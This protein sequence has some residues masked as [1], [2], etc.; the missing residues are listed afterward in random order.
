MKTISNIINN[1]NIKTISI[2]EDLPTGGA[3]KLYLSNI[4]YIGRK[5]RIIKLGNQD[6]IT[7]IHNIGQYYAH[8][9]YN[10][11]IRPRNSIIGLNK[12]KLLLAY[13]SWATKSPILLRYSN[14]PVIYV[15]HELP[16]EFYDKEY[17][18]TFSIKEKVIN[19]IGLIIKNIDLKNIQSTRN[20]TI[21][22]NSKNS[23]KRIY[24]AYR[25]MPKI[26]YPGINYHIFGDNLCYQDRLNSVISVGAIN[27]LKNQLFIVKS[28][29]AINPI[30]RPSLI[31]VGNGGNEE[32]IKQITRFAKIKHV[33]LKIYLNISDKKLINL[34]KHSKAFIYSPINE[35]FGIVV[36]E[37]MAAG[38][39]LITTNIG[40]FSEIISENNGYTNPTKDLNICAKNIVKMLIHNDLWEKYSKYNYNYSHQFSDLKMNQEYLKIINKC[41]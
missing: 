29:A 17:I 38:L 5:L 35:P 14:V 36:L 23:A 26:V 20:L 18:N 41:I 6:D 1:V 32:Y 25:I 33:K 34:Y 7:K 16:R 12:S 9:L 10:L 13:S 2:Y 24:E 4:E 39:P 21:I 30:D 22:T 37:A 31:L 40:G 19:T 15:C 11:I 28:I 8:I 27:K 3:K